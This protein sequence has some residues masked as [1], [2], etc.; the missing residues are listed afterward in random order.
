MQ[1]RKQYLWEINTQLTKIHHQ[2]R[3]A[4]LETNPINFS[5]ILHEYLDER[6]GLFY[7]KIH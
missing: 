2:G 3:Q 7:G 5:R 6:K 4:F 1:S